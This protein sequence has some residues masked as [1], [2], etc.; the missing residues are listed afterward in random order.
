MSDISRS[1]GIWRHR[2]SRRKALGWG[3][4]GI[5]GMGIAGC[6]NSSA[7]P[8]SAPVSAPTSAPASS[9]GAQASPTTARAAPKY[10]GTLST[11]IDTGE[12]SLDPHAAAGASNA[13]SPAIVYSQM[14]TLK[15]GP[16]FKLP[17]WIPGPDLAES[18][19]QADD[20]TYVFKLR[21]GVKWHNIAPVNG[22]ELVADDIV[23]SYDRVRELK[24]YA[25]L[26]SG[27]VKT[28]T[29]DNYTVKLTLS[30]PDADFLV[31]MTTRNLKIVP[32][33]VVA[34]NGDL[35]APPVIG[36]GP[37]IFERWSQTDG[38]SVKRNPDYFRKGFPYADGVE[39]IRT[40][41]F[42]NA[43]LNAFRTGRVNMI[44]GVPRESVEELKKTTPG[45]VSIVIPLDRAPDN[46]LINSTAEPLNNIKVRQA[47]SKAID[48]QQIIAAP[49]LGM[50][51]LYSPL[52]LPAAD[53]ALPE[54]EI[55]RLLER[56]VEGAKR[57]L[58]EAGYE[59]GFD[60][61]VVVPTYIASFF[62]TVAE[63]MQQNLK[64]VNIRLNIRPV[65]AATSGQ[66]Q[67]SGNFQ[68]WLGGY[69]LAGTNG[70]LYSRY[71]TGGPRN[72]Q[73]YNNAALNRLIDQQ[74]VLARDPDARKKIL[75]DIQRMVI[76]DAINVYIET[77]QSPFQYAKEVKD[78]F[79]PVE[80]NTSH[81]FWQTAWIDK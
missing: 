33:E 22:R 44:A 45:S 51:S 56:D 18:W 1:P 12:T 14:I 31:T 35:R 8:T 73:G 67:A 28:E 23:F 58:K 42:G 81:D 59:Q 63:L 76:D 34:Q 32:K 64:D 16:D 60:V 24:T 43:G 69:G 75:L 25:A 38:H 29:P 66:L 47:I 21:Q 65:D 39:V 49:N 3:A 74:A 7:V 54:D 53:W 80:F 40:A 36:T 77:R 4:V 19:Q 20:L 9:Q 6:L 57:L 55:K 68:M 52:A 78:L 41:D 15:W 62:V 61:S 2:L 11:I 30:K 79:L 10:G 26:L 13:T 46:L 50:A 5:A 71:Y 72:V 27:I 48:R 17:S 37:W 70:D